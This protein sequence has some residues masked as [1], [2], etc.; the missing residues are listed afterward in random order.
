MAAGAKRTTNKIS[1]QTCYDKHRACN[2]SL[3]GCAE[4]K[5]LGVPCIY[6][7][8]AAN[9]RPTTKGANPQAEMDKRVWARVAAHEQQPPETPEEEELVRLRKLVAAQKKEIEI[10]TRIRKTAVSDVPVYST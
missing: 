9:G 2:H 1:C 7:V 6:R 5:R 3:A 10:E 8:W 4:C